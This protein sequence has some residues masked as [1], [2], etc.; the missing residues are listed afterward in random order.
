MSKVRPPLSAKKK[1]LMEGDSA[2]MIRQLEEQVQPVIGVN[3]ASSVLY[4]GLIVI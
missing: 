1:P 3:S 2:A 4:H